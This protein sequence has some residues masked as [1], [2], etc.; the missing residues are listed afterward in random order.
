MCVTCMQNHGASEE[1][2]R[3]AGRAPPEKSMR[4]VTQTVR[5]RSIQRDLGLRLSE[6]S[7]TAAG[8]RWVGVV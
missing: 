5:R 6:E 2:M 7:A 4:Q 8:H 1:E 3:L